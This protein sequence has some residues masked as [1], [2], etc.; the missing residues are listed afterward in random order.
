MPA[1]FRSHVLGTGLHLKTHKKRRM[2][3][4]EVQVSMMVLA[5]LRT[6]KDGKR[7]RYSSKMENL[8]DAIARE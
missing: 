5:P 3:Q 7:R 4:P 6:H 1:S 8:I 2:V